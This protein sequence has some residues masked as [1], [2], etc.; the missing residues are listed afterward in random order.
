[1]KKVIYLLFLLLIT[2]DGWTQDFKPGEQA[3]NLAEHKNV[4]VDYSTGLFHYTVP[5]CGIKSGNYE[6]PISL[7]YIGKGVKC[8]DDPGMLGY[9]WTLNTGGIVTRAVR[10]GI[11]DETWKYGYIWSEIKT[12]P[13]NE[14]CKDVSLRKRDGESDIFTAIFNGKKVAFVIHAD[15]NREIYAEPLEYTNVR[16]KCEMN[17]SAIEGWTITDENG[18]CYIYR[19]K[20]L[21]MNVCRENVSTANRI[22]NS[23][24]TSSWYLTKII[25]YNSAPIDFIYRQNME[26]IDPIEKKNVNISHVGELFNMT[27][28]YG[29]PVKEYPFDFDKYSG[30]FTVDMQRASAYLQEYSLDIQV[31]D[32]MRQADRFMKYGEWSSS[33]IGI[34]L[35]QNFRVIGL[36]G[37][38]A[39][40]REAS[41]SLVRTIQSLEDY[42][43]RLDT[44]KPLMAASCLFNARQA[45]VRCMTEVSDVYEK[46]IKGGSSYDVYSP[47]LTMIVSSDRLVE[48][49]YRDVGDTKLLTSIT[50]C[51][52]YKN[53][54]SAV[55]IDCYGTTLNKLSFLDK[56][57]VETSNILFSYYDSS[58]PSPTAP[59]LGP[60]VWGY[61]RTVSKSD[62]PEKPDDDIVISQYSLKN[63]TL[64]SGGE[65]AIGYEKNKVRRPNSNLSTDYGGIRI[66]SLVFTEG[67]SSRKDTILYSYPKSGKTV[68][69]FFTQSEY[70]EYPKFT[71][72]I[73]YDRMLLKGHLFQSL[74][75]NG[76]FY[77]YVT[78]TMQGKGT[79]AY[80]YHSPGDC[81]SLM[82][83]GLL[84]GRAIYDT[85]GELR[86]MTKYIYETGEAYD[87]EYFIRNVKFGNDHSLL[88]IQ[89]SD[90]YL[91]GESLEPFYKLQNN[92][93]IDGSGLYEYNIKPRLNPII[94]LSTMIYEQSYGGKTVLKEEL[95][96][97]FAQN[98]TDSVDYNDFFMTLAENPF[99]KTEYYYDNRRSMAPNR[100]EKSGSD[101]NVYATIYKR[102][103]DMND[104]IDPA[105]DKM[106]RENRLSPV[107]K[108]ITLSNNQVLS[109]IVYQYAKAKPD[110]C[111]I[112]LSE[113]LMYVPD[114]PVTYLENVGNEQLFTYGK[115][116]YSR[117]ASCK[118]ICNN[119]FCLPIEEDAQ[120]QK[121]SYAYDSNDHLSLDCNGLGGYAANKCRY[122]GENLYSVEHAVKQLYERF[123]AFDDM[124]N[125]LD[126]YSINNEEFT[127][128]YNSKNH[129]TI[130]EFIKVFL[131]L[132]ISPDL[133]YAMK[134]EAEINEDLIMEFEQQYLAFT[135]A[136]PQ[137]R[138]LL[139]VCTMLEL[140]FTNPG[141]AGMPFIKYAYLANG[142]TNSK[143]EFSI[144][145][146][147]IPD[148]KRFRIYVLEGSDCISCQ[149]THAG[150]KTEYVPSVNLNSSSSK[151]KVFDVDL[152]TYQNVTAIDVAPSSGGYIAL[153]PI[154]AS[155]E[156]KYYNS[157]GTIYAK[158]D[159]SGKVEFYTYDRAGRVIQ[160]KDQYEN[161]LKEYEYNQIINQ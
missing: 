22:L 148:S 106:K 31:E 16:I 37:S 65:I 95:E 71:D 113:Q 5:V 90:Y 158:F 82:I 144:H 131:E 33:P 21:S 129:K 160:I 57:N 130:I 11:A 96:Y 99:S 114:S 136:Y 104:G 42:C 150:G 46:E 55:S 139:K 91:D 127:R 8:Y 48:F 84:L 146:T 133:D 63:I 56:D 97:K 47:L 27:Y 73:F 118:Y 69:G 34:P 58:R 30:Q 23:E 18:D 44:Y 83:N 111:F 137:Y 60:D 108:Q 10:G 35:E 154:G 26:R 9:N 61:Y 28:C 25:P 134:L 143:Y 62:D 145:A 121:K 138:N 29:S 3:K 156:A 117:I 66:K 38:I 142:T 109:E 125:A 161:I 92:Q 110:T 17:A 39:N 50:Q 88:Q 12:I 107:I 36:L 135:K 15:K 19:Q 102:V 51:D 32:A 151:L 140:A 147:T 7:N 78:E 87:S 75:N 64:Q 20:E 153:V 54:I 105:I 103:M 79:N 152:N 41:E 45:V 67:I 77:P 89:G 115:D 74:G 120:T 122:V 70:I 93:Y 6:L 2:L 116:N 85:Q 49:K 53:P 94:P 123:K 149:V 98:R 1:M 14:D 155:F 128:Y 40:A 86:Q 59:N 76:L 132:S 24:F 81:N 159:Q 157:D 119:N 43:R 13:S 141:T 100:I 112:V 4:M 126:I 80:L 101:G 52:W 72:V 124:Y 68:Y